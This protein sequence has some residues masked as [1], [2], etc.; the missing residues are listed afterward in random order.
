MHFVTALNVLNNHGSW[1]SG[2]RTG[3]SWAVISTK[4]RCPWLGNQRVTTKQGEV[5]CAISQSGQRISRMYRSVSTRKLFS[6]FSFGTSHIGQTQCCYSLLDRPEIVRSYKGCRWFSTSNKEIWWLDLP[7]DHKFL[8]WQLWILETITDVQSWC[9]SWPPNGSRSYPCKQKISQGNPEKF[10]KVPAI[11]SIWMLGKIPWNE[12]HICETSQISYLMVRRRMRDVLGNHCSIW[13]KGWVLPCN[14]KR[15]DKNPPI[16]KE[17]LT[18]G[19][20]QKCKKKIGNTNGSS[21]ALQDMQEK[22]AWGDPQ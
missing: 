2:Q 17:S 18:W 3:R 20:R 6:W 14:C 9:R 15:P 12:T 5:D 22:Q 8:Q 11:G 19:N 21:H 10:A 16:W 4:W 13:F 1:S 7:A